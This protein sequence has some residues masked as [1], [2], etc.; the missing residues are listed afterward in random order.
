MSNLT[1]MFEIV[2]PHSVEIEQCVLGSMLIETLAYEVAVEMLTY[3]DFYIDRSRWL[4]PQFISIFNRLHSL[5]EKIV[6][7]ELT[8][9]RP[10]KEA[11]L[12]DY[13]G[14]LI[15]VPTTAGN[16]EGYCNQLLELKAKRKRL[17]FALRII[18]EICGS[19]ITPTAAAKGNPHRKNDVSKEAHA[20]RAG[21]TV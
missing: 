10:E 13:I 19:Q 9:R 6:V 20:V 1:K 7:Q 8:R 17:N 3:E 21:G 2:P 15:L 4:F 12:R 16:I 5:D 11:E 14:K 18:K